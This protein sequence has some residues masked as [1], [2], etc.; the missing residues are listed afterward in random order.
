MN[1]K[2]SEHKEIMKKLNT[3][4]QELEELKDDDYWAYTKEYWM[5]LL[6][7]SL[8]MLKKIENEIN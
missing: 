8:I 7:S 2:P 3:I 5:G 1:F 4:I 6:D